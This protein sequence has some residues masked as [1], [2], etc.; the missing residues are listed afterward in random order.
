MVVVSGFGVA[1]VGVIST[2]RVIYLSTVGNPPPGWASTIS[3]TLL[4]VGAIICVQGIIGL[5][6]GRIFS[7]VKNR[8][9]FIIDETT[10]S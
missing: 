8:P 9:L 2:A 1:L 6:I 3:I 7:E 4:G 10:D 5:Y